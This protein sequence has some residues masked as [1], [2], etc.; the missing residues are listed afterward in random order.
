MSL[1]A[2]VQSVLANYQH[3]DAQQR[4]LAEG[5]RRFVA[6]DP[7]TVWRSSRVGHI[8]ASSL[9][10]DESDGRVLL[11]LHPKVGRWL[12]LGGHLEPED[13]TL[14]EAALREVREESGIQQGR[15]RM[16]PIR[17]DRHDVPCGRDDDGRVLASVHWD[18]QFL[19]VVPE[20]VD[21]VISDESDDLAWFSRADLPDVDASVAALI[22]D[23][24]GAL[25]E[26]GELGG[27]GDR[28]WVTFG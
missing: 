4:E 7:G 19:V 20:A 16:L 25:G 12:Q 14:L 27:S 10:V 9:V 8:T 11:T 3:D 15:I 26:L 6:T 21:L 18:V 13:T 17:L 23:A 24:D 1:H 28:D 5:Y 22:R 2:D